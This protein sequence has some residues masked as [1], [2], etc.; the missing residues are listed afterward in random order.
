MAAVGCSDFY[1]NRAGNCF[2]IKYKISKD[3][4]VCLSV[5]LSVY[6]KMCIYGCLKMCIYGYVGYHIYIK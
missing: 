3:V 5:C 4:Y 1:S 2:L 6:L